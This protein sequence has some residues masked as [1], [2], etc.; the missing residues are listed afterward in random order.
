[1]AELGPHFKNITSLEFAEPSFS[2]PNQV[3][4]KMIRLIQTVLLCLLALLCTTVCGSQIVLSGAKLSISTIDGS[5]RIS[6]GF[7]LNTSPKIPSPLSIESD[8]VLRLAFTL[9]GTDGEK[10]PAIQQPHQIVVS[11]TDA[12]N[13]E[14]AYTSIVTV[15]RSSGKATW[16]QKF[17][18]LPTSLTQSKSGL[19]KATLLIGSFEHSTAPVRLP[20]ATIQLP[21]SLLQDSAPL[22]PRQRKEAQQ[23]FGRHEDHFHTFSE[24]AADHMPSKSI[25]TTV[26]FL[27]LV[28]PWAFFFILYKQIAPSLNIQ[29]PSPQ[30]SPFVIS[31]VALELLAFIYW[32]GFGLTLFKLIPWLL[33]FSTLTL[34]AGRNALQEMRKV[35]LGKTT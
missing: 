29:T 27:T 23:G 13:E 26:A 31:L 15:K 7:D 24:S 25:T 4:V 16:N 28:I 2:Q 5:A 22:T 12:E 9:Q 1:M 35:R 33:A 11:L 19:L 30:A 18:R 17:N 34:F 6:Q 8:E 3:S 20:L 10:L 21:A 32:Q 14:I